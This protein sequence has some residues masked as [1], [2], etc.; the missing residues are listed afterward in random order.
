MGQQFRTIFCDRTLPNNERCDMR[1]TPNKYQECEMPDDCVGEWFIGKFKIISYHA[2]INEQ[3]KIYQ[4]HGVHV[5][6]TAFPMPLK[7]ELLFA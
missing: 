5:K 6:V 4:D 7:L 2:N 1:L 3:L